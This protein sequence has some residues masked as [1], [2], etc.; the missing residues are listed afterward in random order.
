MLLFLPISEIIV[1]NIVAISQQ[2][3][4]ISLMAREQ[5]VSVVVLA[6]RYRLTP[7]RVR[8]IVRWAGIPTRTYN[9]KSYDI[10]CKAFERHYRT[11]RGYAKENGR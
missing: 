2:I 6:R 1:N 11:I 4:Y 8:Q 9:R 3:I 7:S 10:D 5:F